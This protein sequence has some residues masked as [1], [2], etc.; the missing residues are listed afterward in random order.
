MRGRVVVVL[1]VL[2]VLAFAESARPAVAAPE[3]DGTQS[4]RSG[5]ELYITYCAACHGRDGRGSAAAIAS[6]PLVPPDFTDCSFATREPDTDWLAVTHDGGPARGFDPLMPAYGQALTRHEMQLILGHV[7]RF[8]PDRAWPRGEHNLPRPQV[9]SK[10]FP[11]DE[12]VLTVIASDSRVTTQFVYERRIS[13]RNQVEISVPVVY[14]EQDTGDW[15]GG[16]GDIA[17]SFK[18]VL[19]HSLAR[20]AIV[21][22]AIEVVTPSGRGDRGL[23]GETT[24]FEPFI[25]YGQILPA[26]T[27]AQ[28]QLGAGVPYDRD[29]DDEVFARGVLGWSYRQGRF[30]RTWS[31]MV[32]VLGARELVD[33]ATTQVDLLPQLQ[34][35]LS[36]RQHIMANVG[37]RIPMSDREGRDTQVLAYV[38][39][40]WFDGGFFE[41]W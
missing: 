33:D 2:G 23:G 18:R 28:F 22:G 15:A 11:E 41:G 30:G 27:F 14:A 25:A 32:E 36:Q 31:P 7:R 37:V 24:V 8:C 1:C 39:W 12:A 21:S 29:Y 9:T 35:T 5:S 4:L 13:A 10:A 6:Y 17:L 3:A 34:V 26:Q 38:L 16:I 20:G 40:D 19:A